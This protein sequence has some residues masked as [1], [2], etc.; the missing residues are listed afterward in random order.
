MET[1]NQNTGS[2]RRQYLNSFGFNFVQHTRDESEA[3]RPDYTRFNAPERYMTEEEL[4]Y[5]KSDYAG[6]FALECI[7]RPRD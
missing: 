7:C 2:K 4:K 3:N 5:F 6:T 1:T